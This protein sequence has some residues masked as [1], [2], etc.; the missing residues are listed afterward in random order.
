MSITITIR[1]NTKFCDERGLFDVLPAGDG[2]PE[3]RQYPYEFNCANMNFST[4]WSA[5]GLKV[6]Y[7]G[8]MDP[9]VLLEIIVKTS[10]DLIVR[11]TFKSS[12][13]KNTFGI[14]KKAIIYGIHEK[15][16][17][18]YLDNLIV[19]CGEAIRRNERIT[20]C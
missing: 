10:S 7:C 17:R 18:C 2:F 4:L 14:A 6:E 20:W 13:S 16:A 11:E 12:N 5:L 19:I 1:N 9:R 8:E 15:Q 3:T